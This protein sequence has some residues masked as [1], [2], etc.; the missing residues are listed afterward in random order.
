MLYYNWLI[1]WVLEIDYYLLFGACDLEFTD[2]MTWQRAT[3]E[4]PVSVG[5]SKKPWETSDEHKKFADESNVLADGIAVLK[6]LTIED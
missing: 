2:C 6:W 3:K 1:Y 4:H 5:D